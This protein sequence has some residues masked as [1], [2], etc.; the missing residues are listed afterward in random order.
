MGY[1]LMGLGIL[2][3]LVSWWIGQRAPAPADSGSEAPADLAGMLQQL[4][5]RLEELVALTH[6]PEGGGGGEQ[7]AP[8]P[9]ENYPPDLVKAA[10]LPVDEPEALAVAGSVAGVAAPASFTAALQ[11][12]QRQAL[13]AQ[14]YAAAD[15]GKS[16][17]EIA[18]ECRR[19]KGEIE[20]ILNLRHG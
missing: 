5:G 1:L 14:V 4:S 10:G 20:L 17:E 8:G 6:Q 19:D 11:E 12:A 2:L 18:R 7:V 13:Y 3:L 15:A 9:E 16:L